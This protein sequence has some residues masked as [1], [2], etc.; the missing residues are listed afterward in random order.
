MASLIKQLTSGSNIAVS[1]DGQGGVGKTT[2]AIQIASSS[3]IQDYFPDGVLWA[4]LGREPNVTGLLNGW[5]DQVGVDVSGIQDEANKGKAIA[6]RIADRRMLLVVDDAWQADPAILMRCGGPNCRH[7]LT[8]RHKEVA[9]AFAGQESNVSNL[10]PLNEDQAFQLMQNLAPEACKANPESA[11][12]LSDAV[13]GLPLAVELLGGYL[14]GMMFQSQSRQALDD[15]ADP[16]KRLELAKKRLGANDS[17]KV[18][19]NEVIAMSV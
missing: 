15:L 8:T 11:R 19:L 14:S 13:G 10:Q 6:S 18:T 17:R 3:E 12:E 2:L 7:L 1:A 5:G 4:S 9:T 16:A